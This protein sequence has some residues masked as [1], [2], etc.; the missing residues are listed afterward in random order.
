MPGSKELIPAVSRYAAK[1]ILIVR[2][3]PFISVLQVGAE[4]DLRK[5]RNPRTV[6]SLNHLGSLVLRSETDVIVGT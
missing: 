1:I 3:S 4:L 5:S 2:L 6:K